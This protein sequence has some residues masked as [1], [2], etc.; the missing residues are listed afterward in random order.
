MLIACKYNC[1]TEFIYIV[2]WM[3]NIEITHDCS[4]QWTRSTTRLSRSA[5]GS[6]TAAP[7]QRHYSTSPITRNNSNA[8]K[9]PS[10]VPLA[11]ICRW[12]YTHTQKYDLNKLIP[13]LHEE[14]RKN[15]VRKLIS[16]RAV[17]SGVGKKMFMWWFSARRHHFQIELA[18]MQ[19]ILSSSHIFTHM[20]RKR[21][22]QVHI[23]LGLQERIIAR[24][25]KFE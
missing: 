14:R 21:S 12:A 25:G 19:F 23:I 24:P 7:I 20:H 1:R 22:D 16:F 9:I 18:G 13:N 3:Q 11:A 10:K 17:Y 4:V 2:G 8:K 15:C 6:G 5:Y